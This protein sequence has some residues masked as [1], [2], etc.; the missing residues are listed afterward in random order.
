MNIGEV[1]GMSICNAE[2]QGTSKRGLNL[3][4]QGR[5]DGEEVRIDPSVWFS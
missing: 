2:L 3:K 4:F 1:M 5:A